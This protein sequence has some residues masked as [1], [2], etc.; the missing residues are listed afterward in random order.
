[1]LTNF[2]PTVSELTSLLLLDNFD[3]YYNNAN[4]VR[5]QTSGDVI[6]IRALLEF[7]NYCRRNCQYCGLN[8]TNT[9]AVRFR[10]NEQEIIELAYKAFD[11]GYKTIVL[12]S[13]EDNHFTAQILGDIVK[14]IKK[15]GITITLSCGEMSYEDYKYLRE[16]G[17]DRYLL[18]HET[19]DPDIY[20]ALHPKSR[21]SDRVSCLKN[22]KSLGYA[23][24]S[25]F[26][27]GLPNQTAETIARDILLLKEID[28][29]MAGIGPFIPHPMTTLANLEQGSTDLTL[30]AVALTRMILPNAFLPATTSLGVIDK[31][32]KSKVFDCGANVVMQKITPNRIKRLYEIYPSSLTD[33]TIEQ[34]RKNIEQEIIDMERIPL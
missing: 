4:E 24:G 7:S 34:G 28:C 32:K 3:E 33:F 18:K 22:L 15:T 21:L 5:K 23:T 13:G 12:Q 17:A 9:T 20:A 2:N 16:C 25:G 31:S 1:M 8:C 27:I 14:E 11:A 6:H 30:R 29:D 26:M 10:L 19:A